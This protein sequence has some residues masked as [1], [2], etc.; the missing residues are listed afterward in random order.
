ML[1]Q[2]MRMKDHMVSHVDANLNMFAESCEEV[3]QRLTSMCDQVS[4]RSCFLVKMPTEV[5]VNYLGFSGLIH[6]G[7]E[8]NL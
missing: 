7:Y 5:E 1:G 8:N 3:K 2:F 6:Q 4:L